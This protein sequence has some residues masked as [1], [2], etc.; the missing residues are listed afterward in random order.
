MYPDELS[1]LEVK[2]TGT[3]PYWL[4]VLL[5][6][7]GCRLQ[8]HSKYCNALE[9]SDPVLRA[10]LAPRWKKP[11]PEAGDTEMN[12]VPSDAGIVVPDRTIFVPALG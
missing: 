4:S 12:M 10:M 9:R 11:L 5:A 8:S 2:I 1:V 7:S 3:I 6:T